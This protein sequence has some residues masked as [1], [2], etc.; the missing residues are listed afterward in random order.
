[1]LDGAE[2]DMGE[3]NPLNSQ[4]EM[5]RSSFFQVSCLLF[6]YPTLTHHD[7]MTA[8]TIDVFLRCVADQWEP[9]PS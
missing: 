2:A 8:A 6:L 5:V 4:L 9:Q 7:I 1:M 3:V